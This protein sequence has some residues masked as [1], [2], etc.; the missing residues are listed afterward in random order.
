MLNVPAGDTIE[1]T[2]VDLDIEAGSTCTYDYIELR[3]GGSLGSNSIGKFCGASLPSPVRYVSSGNQLF[4]KIRSDDSITGRGFIAS[5]KI[6][7]CFR[8]EL[9]QANH[10]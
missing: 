3:D 10:H 5:W 9:G 4:V 1:F 8:L 6:G 7:K 2:F